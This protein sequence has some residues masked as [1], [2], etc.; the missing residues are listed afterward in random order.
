MYFAR[1]SHNSNNL[2]VLFDLF[3]QTKKASQLNPLIQRYEKLY[4]FTINQ[5][6][7]ERRDSISHMT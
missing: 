6:P 4:L 7:A 2:D 5:K 1:A 3:K